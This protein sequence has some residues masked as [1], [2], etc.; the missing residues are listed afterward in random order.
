MYCLVSEKPLRLFIP[1]IFSGGI[2]NFLLSTPRAF[3]AGTIGDTF[4]EFNKFCER[5]TLQAV[6][7]LKSKKQKS[8]TETF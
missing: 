5:T 2:W 8:R 6:F 1:L 7:R 3:P 4:Y